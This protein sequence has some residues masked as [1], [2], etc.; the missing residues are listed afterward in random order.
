MRAAIGE[1]V[2]A[3]GSRREATLGILS[4]TH[5]S[6]RVR[7]EHAYR[8][9]PGCSAEDRGLRRKPRILSRSD[10][11]ESSGWLSRA[12]SSRSS[13]ARPRRTDRSRAS[14]RRPSAWTMVS[15][16][17]RGSSRTSLTVSAVT[18]TERGSPLIM[19]IS[20]RYSPG[21]TRPRLRTRLPS[22]VRTISN[23]PDRMI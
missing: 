22:S 5:E 3:V 2:S 9:L 4:S 8:L 16:V 1:T 7:G 17:E 14:A 20:P 10:P 19:L 15:S 6:L 11:S 18:L 23:M 13:W 21:P 12:A